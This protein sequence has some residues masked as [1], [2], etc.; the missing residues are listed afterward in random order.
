LRCPLDK[1][2]AWDVYDAFGNMAS[3]TDWLGTGVS[4][5]HDPDGN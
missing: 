5:S 4:F 1:L 3:V 2:E